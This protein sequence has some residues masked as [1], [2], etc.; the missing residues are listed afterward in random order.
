M[1]KRY[2]FFEIHDNPN[3]QLPSE[4]KPPS[5][6]KK[7]QRVQE[8]KTQ[9]VWEWNKETYGCKGHGVEICLPLKKR[10]SNLLW[11]SHGYHGGAS[12]LSVREFL[13]TGPYIWMPKDETMLLYW[14]LLLQLNER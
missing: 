12:H 4:Q 10:G 11:Y 5:K 3:Y 1:T 8:L 14:A 9:R 7:Q 13:R 6:E 2:T